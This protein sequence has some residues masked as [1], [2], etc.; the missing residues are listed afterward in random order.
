MGEAGI[1][2]VLLVLV[3]QG[4]DPRA[5]GE[6]AL[7]AARGHLV[8]KAQELFTASGRA[9]RV[10][11][12]AALA[13]VE[14]LLEG[15]FAFVPLPSEGAYPQARSRVMALLAPRKNT[16]DFA[17]VTWGKEAFKSSLDGAR[18]SVLRLPDDPKEADR[19]RLG[20]G[21]RRGEYLSGPDLLKRWWPAAQGFVSTTH[22]A[23][24]PF[25]AGVRARGGEVSLRGALE[26]LARLVG[27]EA[28]AHTSIP[29]RGARPSLSTTSASS[30]RGASRSSPP[31]RTPRGWRKPGVSLPPGHL[32]RP[33]ALEGV[34]N[35]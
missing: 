8:E 17:G 31:W 4:Q 23:A 15:Y 34:S 35:P 19:V 18:E 9:S 6:E 14:D 5:L 24:L 22:M 25:W 21:L 30:T 11:Q 10:D 27:E 1:P 3:P 13:Q 2:N 16:R 12:E 32:L 26:R 20:L 28:H 33:P 29:S 7:R